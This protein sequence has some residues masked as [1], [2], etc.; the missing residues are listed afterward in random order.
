MN[1]VLG[2]AGGIRPIELLAVLLGLA[3]IVLTWTFR[4]REAIRRLSWGHLG[5]SALK[6]DEI[7]ST[8]VAVW[9]A[10][11]T[12]RATDIPVLSPLAVVA[13][14]V[15]DLKGIELV[16]SNNPANDVKVHKPYRRK[17]ARITFAYLDKGDGFV[18][19]VHHTGPSS[20]LGLTGAIIGGTGPV[21]A[22]RVL[23][24][25]WSYLIGFHL[26]GRR[27]AVRHLML[28]R[29]A[30]SSTLLLTASAPYVF[31]TYLDEFAPA[32]AAL[33]LIPTYFQL[34]W[35]ILQW[36]PGLPQ[37]LEAV[38]D[39]APAASREAVAKQA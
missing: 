31:W 23:F 7:N 28:E 22:G 3:G 37:G 1:E 15:A 20:D 36:S 13:G 11:P 24:S 26:H 30:Y 39:L 6:A 33:Y 29:Y 19:R 10:G 14:P 4:P 34:R 8:N 17:R 35:L 27:R 18:L 38:L 16:T 25:S 9:N 12:V 21:W 2:I 32:M 5:H